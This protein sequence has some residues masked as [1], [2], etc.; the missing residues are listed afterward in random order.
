MSQ[1]IFQSIDIF[2]RVCKLDLHF[3][4]YFISKLSKEDSYKIQDLF[5]IYFIVDFHLV[6][7]VIKSPI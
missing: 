2:F 7:L 1:F 5:L 6:I 4:W 3:L